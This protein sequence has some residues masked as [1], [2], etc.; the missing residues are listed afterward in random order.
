MTPYIE[1]LV[2]A[3]GRWRFARFIRVAHVVHCGDVMRA[4]PPSQWPAVQ[5]VTQ[6]SEIQFGNGVTWPSDHMIIGQHDHIM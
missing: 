3:L 5:T 6:G 4:I 2:Q 1:G